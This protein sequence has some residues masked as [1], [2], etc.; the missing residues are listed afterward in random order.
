[1]SSSVSGKKPAVNQP[2]TMEKGGSIRN[3]I[4]PPPPPKP[5]PQQKPPKESPKK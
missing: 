2:D 5:V 1:M 4:V 3:P